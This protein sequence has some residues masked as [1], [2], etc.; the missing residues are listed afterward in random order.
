MTP[1]EPETMN[2]I[3]LVDKSGNDLT[4]DMKQYL[5]YVGYFCLS[6]EEQ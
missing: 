6:K 1:L 4:I 5:V 2:Q 3:W